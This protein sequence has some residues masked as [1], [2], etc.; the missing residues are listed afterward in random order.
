M[1]GYLSL[2]SN[3]WSVYLVLTPLLL[4]YW[5]ES[6][7]IAW[8]TLLPRFYNSFKEKSFKNGLQLTLVCACMSL[9]V[10]MCSCMCYVNECVRTMCVG[11]C[12]FFVC[13]RMSSFILLFRVTC[14][15]KF[16]YNRMKFRHRSYIKFFRAPPTFQRTVL[17]WIQLLCSMSLL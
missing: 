7:L 15:R 6:H 14:T 4:L 8:K 2:G 9:W 17:G 16:A 11:L 10:S 5:I 1:Y 3:L 13:L 12:T